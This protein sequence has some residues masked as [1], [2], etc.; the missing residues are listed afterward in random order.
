MTGGARHYLAV[1][2]PWAGH[3]EVFVMDADGQLVGTTRADGA[4]TVASAARQWLG[5]RLGPASTVRVT[6]GG[7]PAAALQV[8]AQPGPVRV[9]PARRT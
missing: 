2:A 4:D 5:H 3:W 8:P 9:R 1:G 6:L 7:T